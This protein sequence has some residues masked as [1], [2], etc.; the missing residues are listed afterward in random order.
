[1]LEDAWQ[2]SAAS[3][4]QK[5]GIFQRSG[6]YARISTCIHKRWESTFSKATITGI[7]RFTGQF[8]AKL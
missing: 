2:A 8:A 6:I 4:T 7:G 5:R 3:V 1:L